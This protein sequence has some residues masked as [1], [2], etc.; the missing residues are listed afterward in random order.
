MDPGVSYLLP[1]RAGAARP[2]F[3]SDWVCKPHQESAGTSRP[4]LRLDLSWGALGRFGLSS[5]ALGRI[6]HLLGSLEIST[7]SRPL[8]GF[9]AGVGPLLERVQGLTS[10]WDHCI[11]VVLTVP[12]P[13]T[14]LPAPSSPAASRRRWRG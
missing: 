7:M 9:A 12:Y 14:S 3:G 6:Y 13:R 1:E 8:P 10:P 4:L 5:G 2:L 11:H